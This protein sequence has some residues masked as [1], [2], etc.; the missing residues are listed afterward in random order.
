MKKIFQDYTNHQ[1]VGVMLYDEL[2]N[3]MDFLNL[4][5]YKRQFEYYA[6]E[7]QIE[8]RHFSRYFINHYSKIL[9]SANVERIEITP[10]QY[11]NY[12]REDISS[13]YKAKYVKES[14]SKV[15]EYYVNTINFL[16]QAIKT[17]VDDNHIEDMCI[18]KERLECYNKRLKKL[19]RELIHLEDIGYDINTI[20]TFLQPKKHEKFKKKMKEEYNVE[21]C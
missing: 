4:H 3:C 6:I 7:E 21:Y 20:E 19:D 1:L 2:A 9:K 12:E 16:N 13:D 5:G 10:S 11:Y 8:R 14:L 15:R 17:L 18:F